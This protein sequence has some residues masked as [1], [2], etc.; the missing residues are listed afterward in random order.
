MNS[1]NLHTKEKESELKGHDDAVLDL[2]F[3]N[4][5]DGYLITASFDHLD[6]IGAKFHDYK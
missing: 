4:G 5:K 3:D 6:E 1:F 2:C